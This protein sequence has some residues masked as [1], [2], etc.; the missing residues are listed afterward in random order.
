[1]ISA[2]FVSVSVLLILFPVG[3]LIWEL[4]GFFGGV[5][6]YIVAIRPSTN[7]I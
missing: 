3:R 4:K 6:G 2:V 5:P 1:M 7:H